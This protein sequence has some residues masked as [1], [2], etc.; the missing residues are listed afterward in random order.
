MPG[1]AVPATLTRELQRQ[2]NHELSAAHSYTALS[3]WCL[4]RNLKGFAKYFGKQAAEE[5]EHA[6]RFMT[7]LLDRGI[8]PLVAAI[9]AP[10]TRFKSLIEAARHAQDMERAN[11]A[12]IHQAYD[13][14]LKAKDYPA[15]VLLH[16]FISEQVEEEAWTDEMVERC[17]G[18]T[19]EGAMQALDRHIERY[20]AD[21]GFPSEA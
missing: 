7:H 9:E 21:N 10:K 16:W 4:E 20:L 3:L 14:A 6:Q 2:M 12:G 8:L 13:S 17:E 1:R 18:A 5:R 19:T 15:Q 11:T